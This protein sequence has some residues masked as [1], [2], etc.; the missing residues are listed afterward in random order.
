MKIRIVIDG[1][2]YEFEDYCEVRELLDS[3]ADGVNQV[4]WGN[5][6]YLDH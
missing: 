5:G 4:K 6:V 3:H 2:S 1:T